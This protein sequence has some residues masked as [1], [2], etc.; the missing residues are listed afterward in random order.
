MKILLN[1]GANIDSGTHFGVE[2]H[3]PLHIAVSR[4][5]MQALKFLIA[6][7]A[8]INKKDG[9]DYTPLHWACSNRYLEGVVELL[10]HNPEVNTVNDDCDMSPLQSAVHE[11]HLEIVQEL[12][13]HDANIDFTDCINRTALHLATEGKYVEIVKILLKNGCDTRIKAD[14]L[15]SLH[16]NWLWKKSLL[17]L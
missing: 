6:N 7:G 2:L 14:A 10:K 3:T 16:L 8:N 17:T 12:L 11:G 1:F 13:K 5:N 4:R 9:H 15:F